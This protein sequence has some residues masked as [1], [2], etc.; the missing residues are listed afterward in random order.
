MAC[1]T[2]R[3]KD[4]DFAWASESHILLVIDGSEDKCKLESEPRS[5]LNARWKGA[6]HIYRLWALDWCAISCRSSQLATFWR[7]WVSL[8]WSSRTFS[9][10]TSYFFNDRRVAC[11]LW[12]L[13]QWLVH[14][15][16]GKKFPE[17]R[18][19]F[20]GAFLSAFIGL[21]TSVAPHNLLRSWCHLFHAGGA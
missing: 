7:E 8:L 12:L 2:S 21:P 5:E 1:S 14:C 18:S 17:C 11:V 3:E 6:L 16:V 19:M 15:C 10:D 13:C 20:I 4:V 9:V